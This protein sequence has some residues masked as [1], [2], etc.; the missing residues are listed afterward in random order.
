M[1]EAKTGSHKVVHRRYGITASDQP[2]VLTHYEDGRVESRLLKMPALSE[3]L[4]DSIAEG[5]QLLVLAGYAHGLM[6][7]KTKG[8]K[9]RNRLLGE[10][11]HEGVRFGELRAV[12]DWSAAHLRRVLLHDCGLNWAR[13]KRHSPTGLGSAG[14]RR[15]PR[16]KGARDSLGASPGVRR[17]GSLYAVRG[18][19]ACVRP[20]GAAFAKRRGATESRGAKST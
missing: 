11:I 17:S 12:L 19:H 13:I 2:Y 5:D 10:L 20:K 9:E 18:L 1:F 16:E 6:A 15:H 4:G 3:L 8:L 7:G 14:R